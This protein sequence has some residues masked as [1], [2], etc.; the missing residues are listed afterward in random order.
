[1]DRHRTRKGGGVWPATL[2]AV[3]AVG[4]DLTAQA[5]TV[6]WSAP[7]SSH[8]WNT[9]T[10][11]SGGAVPGQTD[12]VV[13][14]A[15]VSNSRL[16]ID[17]NVDVK[18]ITVQG[19]Y[20]PNIVPTGAQTIRVRGN[21]SLGSTSSHTF[22]V[23]TAT[24]QIDGNLIL[25]SGST[26]VFRGNDG[27]LHV[28]GS[29][30]LSA[31]TFTA[32]TGSA[33]VDGSFTV[34]GG[35]FTGSSGLL[36]VGGN[37]SV[38]SGTFN[39]SS[40][41]IAIG[42]NLG[43]LSNG[44]FKASSSTTKIGGAFNRTSTSNTFDAN[45]GALLFN[46][47]SNQSHT[48]N[49]AGFAK[50][51][52]ND[53]LVGYWNLE[54]SASPY[55][56][57]SGY[58]NDATLNGTYT[59]AG[60]RPGVA[61]TDAA[62]IS[63]NGT[64]NYLTLG[65]TSLPAANAAQTVS[66]WVNFS[67]AASTQTIVAMT[68]SG[69]AIKLGLG[70]GNLR[71]LRNDNTVLVQVAA[72][73]ASAWHQVA[74]VYD[75]SLSGASKDKLYVDGT[76]TTGTS[77]SHDAVT[78]TAAYIGA[79]APATNLLTALVD[80]V[81]IYKT[82]LGARE[83]KDLAFGRMPATGTVTHTLSGAF[84]T[85]DG[86]NIGAFVIASG[87]VAGSSAINVEGDWLNY[88]GRFT[89]T[90][91][92]TLNGGGSA[93]VLL[94]GG[95]SFP[96]LTIDTS[97]KYTLSD[98]LWVPGGTLNIA[99]QASSFNDGG[100]V[101]HA[102]TLTT[103]STTGYQ[104]GGGTAVLDGR[105][106]QTI[107]TANMN[108]LRIEAPNET[109]LVGYWKL[110]AGQGTTARDVSGNNNNG[111]LSSSG[112][113]WAAASSSIGFDNPVS[114]SFDGAA[115]YVSVGTTSLPAASAA[116]S[117]SAW[118]KF[119]SAAATQSVLAMTGAGSAIKL[120]LGG[121]NVQVLKNA[122]TLV[123]VA[124]P[125]T[126]TWHHV[127]Y[128]WNGTT[129]ALYIDGVATTT[130]TAHDSGAVTAATI[131]ASGASADFFN[132][133]IDDVRVYNQALTAAQVKSLGVGRYAGTGVSTTVTLGHN[134]TVSSS[135]V[136][137]FLDS[138]V[139]YTSAYTVTVS[140]VG[141]PCR[142]DSGTLHIGSKVV[143]CDGGLTVNT[144]GTLLMDES[145]GQFQPGVNST[146]IID[147]TLR[148]SD[149]G[150]II[151][152]DNGGE[153]YTFKVGST[154]TATPTLDITGLA[155]RDTDASGLWLNANA[156]ATTTISHFDNI[157]FRRGTTTFLTVAGNA[158]YLTSKGCVFGVGDSAPALPTYNVIATGNGTGDGE[159]RAVFG[160]ATCHSSKTTG[161]Y[162]QHTWASDD[163]A[164]ADG[165]G[166]HLT[167]NG[168][169]VQYLREAVTDTTGTIEGF[170]TAAFDWNTFAYYGTYAAFHDASGTADR[171]YVRDQT[172]AA[173]YYWDTGSGE[174][175]VGT[176]R[177]TTSGGTHYLF[178][179][180]ASGKVYRLVDNGSSLAPAAGWTVNPYDCGCTIVSPLGLDSSNLYWAGINTLS[181]G[182]MI[183]TLGQT[184]ESVPIGSP[185]A[186]T[187]T[188]TA[189]SPSTWVSGGTT[190]L[191]LGLAGHLLKVDITN[192]MLSA[193]N[194]NP[195]SASVW[196]RISIG[197]KVTNRVFAG[198]DGGNFWSIDPA[199]FAGTN[200]QWSYAVA[201]DQIKSSPFYD[202]TTNVVHFGTEGGKVV[203]LNASGS[204]LAAGY[205]YTPGTASDSIR[206]A[207][208]YQGGVIAAGTTTGKLYFID[209]NNGGSGPA[210]IREYYFGPTESVSGIGYD[211][212]TSRYMVTTSDATTKDGR[213][214][215]IDVIA[216]PTS[217]AT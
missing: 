83:M 161:G 108:A 147:G 1:M 12:D 195:G 65:A 194:T 143:N 157:A 72:P 66:A 90:G 106:S 181:S 211:S 38:T 207:L 68:A 116:Q 41:I 17:T 204:V 5:A 120:G 15:S 8:G 95:E 217:G 203:A 26:S 92:V 80:E 29:V 3:L 55:S 99:G 174:T 142:V 172:G 89:G 180:L 178:V 70:G 33:Q 151:Q 140:A 188:L 210:L 216:D 11:W 39:G 208:L 150:A 107:T 205:P 112:A 28:L 59:A 67:S 100:Y 18:S 54:E 114:G 13:I 139:L 131:G 156:S 160:S 206:S 177:W 79:T 196:G 209:R 165:V 144:M 138:G 49:G 130:T 126:G 10:N 44:T 146:V 149:T 145:G 153:K 118:I 84:T 37:L 75:P 62:A 176:P 50:V 152:R 215:Y 30:T 135:G 179:A 52:F 173:K 74:Y 2:V 96:N 51:V 91:L 32:D 22:R 88:G 14:D 42:G 25:P 77:Q 6:T 184:T 87:I 185:M 64:S 154:A 214:Y 94:S 81:R 128:S 20:S 115:G 182:N 175:I 200:K 111:T 34:A 125:S 197:T 61:Y 162:C 9:G 186:I 104:L 124:A 141:T 163:D 117:V 56:D 93:R 60:S 155:V 129:N 212:N 27:A 132:G 73:S 85:S 86:S 46:A 192:Q 78:P 102:G 198:D 136:G 47:T 45:G 35:T 21:F 103:N 63:L 137:V 169:V 133:Q 58:A 202:Y 134:L 168:A 164:N 189:T 110:D 16:D 82:A 23:S 171:I 170:P 57:V 193:D 158:F 159:T 48:T 190:Y 105:S 109:G 167:T 166:D 24:T 98:R 122:G 148:A 201:G 4:M 36:Q 183:W 97:G 123:S 113:S 7:G 76:A 199:N 191:F 19:A 53:G 127:A 213:L 40:G 101:F 121:G 187:P 119:S 31:G 69:S 71:V 43:P